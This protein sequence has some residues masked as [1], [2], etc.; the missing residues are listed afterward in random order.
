[1]RI[2]TFVYLIKSRLTALNNLR[3]LFLKSISSIIVVCLFLVSFLSC[4]QNKSKPN[5]VKI[6]IYEWS[7]YNPFII[8]EQANIFSKNGLNAEI[9]RY[10]SAKEEMDALRTGTIQGAA[11]TLEEVIEL[12][13]SGFP[14]KVV[15][16]LDYSMGGDMILGQPEIT[17][18]EQLMGKKIG[19]ESTVISEFLLFQGLQLNG[20]KTSSFELIS[21][22]ATEF[23]KA[24]K[25][26]EIDALVCY[27]PFASKLIEEEKANLLFS[28]AEI[29]FQIIDVLVF[30][31]PFY[32]DNKDVLVKI[33][34]SWFDA[35]KFQ[36][37]NR[38]QAMNIITQ[39][40]NIDSVD[41]RLSL[42]GLVAP[43]LALNKSLFNPESEQNIYK[44]SLPIIN[45]ML[46][47]RLVSKRIN[48]ADLFPKD[49]LD[50]VE[51]KK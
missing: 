23:V 41:Y 17:G 24:F 28:S 30:S 19:H 7:G 49:I 48:T 20:L 6:G 15:L 44:Y 2:F 26:K 12:V 22:P 4:Q 31:E 8:A 1:M 36:N 39:A 47:K 9:N 35:L 42:N 5:D 18:M 14:V 21:I 40:K 11:L 46:S 27:N 34:Q 51:N 43:D 33:T 45:F 16:I 50:T 38:E 29:P 32:N 25:S 10:S 13:S 37:E 3:Y